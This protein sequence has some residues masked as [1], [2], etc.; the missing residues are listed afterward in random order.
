MW[1]PERQEWALSYGQEHQQKLSRKNAAAMRY[2]QNG[3]SVHLGT[4]GNFIPMIKIFKHLC[5]FY[6]FKVVSFFIE[7]LLHSL[8]DDLFWG[9]APV[10]LTKVL[11]AIGAMNPEDWW[12]TQLWTPCGDRNL[13]AAQYWNQENWTIFVLFCRVWATQAESALLAANRNDSIALWQNLL[14]AD[15]FPTND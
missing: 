12:T 6:D 3:M 8:P 5:K 15:Y 10:R 2:M 7:S 11:K 14:G 4:D 9:S 1:R 13:F